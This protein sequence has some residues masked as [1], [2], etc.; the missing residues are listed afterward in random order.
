MRLIL[1]MDT[2]V[3]GS[4][5][6]RPGV[7]AIGNQV[8][9]NKTCLGLFNFRDSGSGTNNRQIAAFDNALSTNAVT[10]YL[11]VATWTAITG[12]NFTA[13]A[14]FR[15]ATFLDSVFVVNSAFD[16]PLSWDGNTSHGW[17]STNLTSAPAGKFIT[18]FNSRLYIAATSANPDRLL[19]SSIQADGVITWDTTNDY[20]DVNPSDG[21]NIT[22]LANNGTL[23]L[24]FKERAMYR[25]NGSSTDANLVVNIGTTSQESVV[26]QNGR[27][28]FFNPEG[29]YVTDGSYPQR[30][31]KLI[32]RWIDAI[33]PSYYSKVSAACDEDNLYVSV[34]NVTVD[35]IAYANA[36][37]VFTFSTQTWRVRTYAE[38]FHVFAPYIS[39]TGA[40]KIMGG[41]DDGDVQDF[42]IGNTDDSTPIS[43]RVRTKKMD[44]GTLSYIK[45]FSDIFAFGNDIPGA[46][47]LI[48]SEDGELKPVRASLVRWFQRM[49]GLKNS[50]R[51]FEFELAGFSKGGQGTFDG[52]EITDLSLDGYTG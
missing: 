22:G 30:L 4:L 15:F 27:T 14:K 29:I 38:Q 3:F 13:G 44:F 18:V 28:Y 51:Y 40:Y 16:T 2:D 21:M 48:R 32:Q 26:T 39:S 9:D 1:N 10:S 47:T 41:N 20:L 12:S 45:K 35:N 31:S 23:I 19:F 17:G 46:Q 50:G 24:I 43:Y 49:V 36:M 37:Y 33:D 8:T 5:R 34:G 6:V 42:N 11:N 7:T 52:W 25:W